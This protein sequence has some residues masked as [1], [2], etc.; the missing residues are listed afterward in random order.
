M[1]CVINLY[2]GS[3]VVDQSK[4][5]KKQML[6]VVKPYNAITLDKKNYHANKP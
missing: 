4:D 3:W 6:R 5:G 1:G 2:L